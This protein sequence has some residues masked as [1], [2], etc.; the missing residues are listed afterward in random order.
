MQMSPRP[1]K[2][3]KIFLWTILIVLII[4]GILYLISQRQP[5]SP[6]VNTDLTDKERT[7]IL[8]AFSESASNTPTLT[9]EQ[10]QAILNSLSEQN[11]PALTDEQKNAILNSLGQ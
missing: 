8:R 4:V 5:V 9:D 10:K 2:I 1:H 6:T 11:V 7:E 3:L